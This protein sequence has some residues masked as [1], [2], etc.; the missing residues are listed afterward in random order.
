MNKVARSLFPG[1]YSAGK[2]RVSEMKDNLI[3]AK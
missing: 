3:Y 2:A 1:L